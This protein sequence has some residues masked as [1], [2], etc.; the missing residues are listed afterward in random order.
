MA[1]TKACALEIAPTR[2]LSRNIYRWFLWARE[3]LVGATRQAHRLSVVAGSAGS[4][5]G[6]GEGHLGQVRRQMK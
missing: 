4:D 6:G 3:S 2:V 5:P 1:G